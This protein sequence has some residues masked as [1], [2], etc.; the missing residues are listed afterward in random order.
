MLCGLFFKANAVDGIAVSIAYRYSEQCKYCPANDREV[1]ERSVYDGTFWG[2]LVRYDIQ[3]GSVADADTLT[4]YLAYY[5]AISIDGSTIA[6]F[7]RGSKIDENN[8]I[9]DNVIDP[10][11]YLVDL[12]GANLRK[13][14]DYS[15]FDKNNAVFLDWP[16]GD[17]IYYHN[18]VQSE[19][20]I[21]RV[22]TQTGANEKVLDYIPPSVEDNRSDL[23]RWSISA[24]GAHAITHAGAG[25]WSS[26]NAHCFPPPDGDPRTCQS[27]TIKDCNL[28]MGASGLYSASYY[29]VGHDF[30]DLYYW[31]FSE[32]HSEKIKR[33]TVSEAADFAG[34][35]TVG[36]GAEWIRWSCNSDKWVL[37]QIGWKGHANK[38]DKSGSNAV[39]INWVD[40]EA[41][42]LTDNPSNTD[43]NAISYCNTAGDFWV[44][45]PL[46]KEGHIQ[47][48]DGSWVAVEHASRTNGRA[49]KTNAS[50]TAT[51]SCAF[52][53]GALEISGIERFSSAAVTVCDLQ[54][55]TIFEQNVA[56]DVVRLD[57]VRIP[58][59]A[60]L[61]HIKAP[62]AGRTVYATRTLAR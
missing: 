45:P 28:S 50:P 49:L 22:N 5:P 23:R 40:E 24:D 52:A 33:I 61:V 27:G 11:I 7:L 14:L 42:M 34:V 13:I 4:E 9:V 10:G 57:A 51:F 46:G 58:A 30:I 20:E 21:W 26:K 1:P 54:G 12:D 25:D 3:G 35:D 18:I 6:F 48:R 56:G 19:G 47:R 29:G 60:F 38:L 55:R 37:Q 8:D 17:W 44:K 15:E 2:S 39:Y 53:G 32:G 59:G 16:A 41:I 62:G 31:D 43:E 36:D